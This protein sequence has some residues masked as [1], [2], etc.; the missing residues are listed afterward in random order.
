MLRRA[1][2]LYRT[3][4]LPDSPQRD[5]LTLIPPT[6]ALFLLSHFPL[7]L[8]R[9][10]ESSH[11]KALFLL[12]PAPH[13][14]SARSS[15]QHPLLHTTKQLFINSKNNCTASV[16]AFRDRAPAFTLPPGRA[17]SVTITAHPRPSRVINFFGI[18]KI[19]AVR[20]T[21]RRES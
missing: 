14:F 4:S 19:I 2:R 5:T 17:R 20:P 9:N 16:C 6:P 1:R 10:S 13:P 12:S 11:S 15:K 21:L 8:S 7:L 3:S 18:N